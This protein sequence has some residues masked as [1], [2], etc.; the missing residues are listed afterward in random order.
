[1]LLKKKTNQIIKI[2]KYDLT[3]PKTKKTK[4]Q[5]FIF[6]VLIFDNKKK[7]KHITF[8]K[9]TFFKICTCLVLLLLLIILKTKM[10]TVFFSNA[11]YLQN[12]KKTKTTA[13]ILKFVL[14]FCSI[15]YKE[16]TEL[17]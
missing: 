11:F 17:I 3:F 14:N 9:T 16:K 5:F 6:Y 12:K 2:K 13:K 7:Q 1:L 4:I 8:V 15:F 10:K